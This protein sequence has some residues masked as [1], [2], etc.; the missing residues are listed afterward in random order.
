MIILVQHSYRE[1]LF[2]TSQLQNRSMNAWSN[3]I[4]K[5]LNLKMQIEG[6]VS[7][8]RRRSQ[9]RSRFMSVKRPRVSSFKR[10]T[11]PPTSFWKWQGIEAITSQEWKRRENIQSRRRGPWKFSRLKRRGNFSKSSWMKSWIGLLIR[12]RLLPLLLKP[13]RKWRWRR[14]RVISSSS[15]LL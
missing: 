12:K 2:L 7:P 14:K 1:C 13:K 9:K 3:G 10:E 4:W 6:G 8:R 15:Q 5:P 11:M